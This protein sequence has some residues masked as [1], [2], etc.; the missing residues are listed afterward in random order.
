[1]RKFTYMLLPFLLP[2]LSGCTR[3]GDKSASLSTIY[4]VTALLALFVLIGYVIFVRKKTV[5]FSTLFVSIFVVNT[6][7]WL[8]S[9]STNLN[10]ALYANSLSYLGSVFLPMSML[11]LILSETHYHYKKWL[12]CLLSVINLLVFFVTASYPYLTI[13][14]EKVVFAPVNGTASLEKTYGPLHHL[15]LVFLLLYFIAIIAVTVHAT[16]NKKFNKKSQLIVFSI[17]TFVNIC[18]WLLGQLAE[19]EFEFLSVSYIISELFLISYITIDDE[20]Y[21]NTAPPQEE[22]APPV[23]QAVPPEEEKLIFF[24]ENIHRL[25]PTEQKI[26]DYYLEGKTTKEI[27]ELLTIKENTLKYHNKNIYS[28]LGVSSRKELLYFAKM[29]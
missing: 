13:Y 3:I 19:T 21:E 29:L 28:K 12:P 10:T 7:Y 18:V 20:P 16:K 23:S 24:T 26:Y 14:Y 17:A 9:V 27:M 22:E 4:S 8:L 15:Y 6:G 11:M 25:T 1:M 5:W 2:I